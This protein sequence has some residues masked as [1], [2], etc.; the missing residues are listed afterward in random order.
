MYTLS[1][2][3]NSG[4]VYCAPLFPDNPGISQQRKGG[5]EFM[6]GIECEHLYVTLKE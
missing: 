1:T 2:A 6:R 5:A 3:G 4:F